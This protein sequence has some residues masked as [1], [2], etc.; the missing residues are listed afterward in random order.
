MASE[1]STGSGTGWLAFLFLIAA[2]VGVVAVGVSLLAVSLP[3]GLKFVLAA[4][5]GMLTL[6]CIGQVQR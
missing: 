3:D 1:K 5:A 6:L 2:F 4:I